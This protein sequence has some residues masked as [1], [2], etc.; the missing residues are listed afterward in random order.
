MCPWNRQQLNLGTSLEGNFDR[1]SA[2]GAARTAG[3]LLKEIFGE[4]WKVSVVGMS[5]GC[6]TALAFASLYPRQTRRLVLQ[7]GV[8]RPWTDERYVPPRFRDAYNTAYQKFGWAGDQVSQVILGSLVAIRQSLQKK[9]EDVRSI[10]GARLDEA[11]EDPAFTAALNRIMR[12]EKQN[13]AGELNDARNIF[14]AKSAYCPWEAVKAGSDI[15]HPRSRGSV[16]S[17]RSRDGGSSADQTREATNIQA[18]RSSHL[19]RDRCSKDAPR[20]VR[21]L[22]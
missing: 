4:R 10:V 16:G 5:G 18:R 7:A 21:F 19:C 9:G 14:L 6:P 1:R 2:D 17:H 22:R 20:P 13:S 15:H 11:R 8:S 12:H 3:S